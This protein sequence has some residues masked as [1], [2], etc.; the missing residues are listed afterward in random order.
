MSCLLQFMFGWRPADGI[1]IKGEMEERGT[2]RHVC[3]WHYSC[4]SM[5]YGG[6]SIAECGI[7]CSGT[8]TNR[9]GRRRCDC[10]WRWVKMLTGQCYL[11]NSASV[12][13]V[14]NN[15]CVFYSPTFILIQASLILLKVLE[16]VVIFL[17]ETCQNTSGQ[18]KMHH[19][20]SIFSYLLIVLM[21][22]VHDY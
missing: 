8:A 1:S 7:N 3:Q 6:T 17:D 22:S 12:K 16:I 13:S 19:F 11:L 9:G 20:L 2:Q 5:V 4:L 14:I 10:C 21:Y 15:S 18:K